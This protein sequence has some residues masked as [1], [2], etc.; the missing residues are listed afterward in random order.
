M[1]CCSDSIHRDNLRAS[2]P[3]AVGGGGGAGDGLP[4]PPTAGTSMG[5]EEE[6]DASSTKA[7]SAHDN[8]EDLDA[9]SPMDKEVCGRPQKYLSTQQI[10]SRFHKKMSGLGLPC[11][12]RFRP[13]SIT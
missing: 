4:E 3:E 9:E 6:E 7:E 11:I 2:G 5:G 1:S 13:I 12:R 10:N 8:Q